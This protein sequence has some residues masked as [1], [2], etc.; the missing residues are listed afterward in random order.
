MKRE[1]LESKVKARLMNRLISDLNQV[2][3]NRAID[4]EAKANNMMQGMAQYQAYASSELERLH[5]VDSRL[6]DTESKLKALQSEDEELSETFDAYAERMSMKIVELK[7]EI[8]GLKVNGGDAEVGNRLA[9]A[10]ALLK[11]YQQQMT[12]LQYKQQ[13]L[14]DRLNLNRSDL[15]DVA[16]Y[17]DVLQLFYEEGDTERYM[18]ELERNIADQEMMVSNGTACVC[19]VKWRIGNSEREGERMT[20]NNIKLHIKRSVPHQFGSYVEPGDIKLPVA[21]AAGRGAVGRTGVQFDD[22][23]CDTA[24]F[25][26]VHFLQMAGKNGGGT[27][28]APAVAGQPVFPDKKFCS[29]GLPE[30]KLLCQLFFFFQSGKG[31]LP[32]ADGHGNIGRQS[33][34]G[35]HFIAFVG[36]AFDQFAGQFVT[37]FFCHFVD[38]APYHIRS[39]SLGTFFRFEHLLAS[40]TLAH[41]A[42]EA[43]AGH[44]PEGA[45]L[46]IFFEIFQCLFDCQVKKFRVG[47]TD[48]DTHL[49]IGFAFAIFL[50]GVEFIFFG[51]FFVH[52]LEAVVGDGGQQIAAETESSFPHILLVERKAALFG[53]DA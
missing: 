5:E 16:M 6:A 11:E 45:D 20:K 49:G 22:A 8:R 40:G 36:T 53:K 32:V 12:K 39:L 26:S 18:M 25:H 42:A 33:K 35:R 13:I 9:D 24:P 43:V 38:K 15:S 27:V 3:M 51:V 29:G 48:V 31:Y 14:E 30:V 1:Q 37:D 19:E 10:E 17:M 34:R 46:G 47:K 7:R 28:G 41:P 44:D 23:A 52:P 4:T 21:P 2:A 50:Q